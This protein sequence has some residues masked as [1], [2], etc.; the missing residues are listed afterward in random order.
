MAGLFKGSAVK[1]QRFAC[2]CRPMAGF[3][4]VWAC[5]IENLRFF[6]S[7][8]RFALLET[9]AWWANFSDQSMLRR[10]PGGPLAGL[11]E[12]EDPSWEAELVSEEEV[13]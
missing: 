12:E 2:R 13:R 9:A 7:N 4:A 6:S 5:Q 1:A 11:S 3:P 10:M 8:P